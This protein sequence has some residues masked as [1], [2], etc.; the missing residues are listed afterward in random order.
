MT[1]TKRTSPNGEML[2]TR[3]IEKAS[4]SARSGKVNDRLRRTIKHAEKE[5]LRI[6]LKNGVYSRLLPPG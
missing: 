1:Q 6:D 3:V 4:S 2:G 5:Q